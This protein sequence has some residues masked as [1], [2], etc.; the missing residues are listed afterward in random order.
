MLSDTSSAFI[1]ISTHD[2]PLFVLIQHLF[3]FD[4]K[5]EGSLSLIFPSQ[6]ITFSNKRVSKSKGLCL[7]AFQQN[8][9]QCFQ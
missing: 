1:P 4:V 3:L 7:R 2:L 9:E 6:S 8:N 5:I